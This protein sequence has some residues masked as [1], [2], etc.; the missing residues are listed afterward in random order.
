[1]AGVAV[2][3]LLAGWTLAHWPAGQLFDGARSIGESLGTVV[4]A[5]LHDPNTDIANPAVVN[6][7]RAL[8][9]YLLGLVGL[10]ALVQALRIPRE[11]LSFAAVCAGAAVGAL[12]LHWIAFRLFGLH[13]PWKR[14]ALYLAPLLTLA[15]CSIAAFEPRPILGACLAMMG[16]YFG[17][18]LRLN[19]SW[20]W[21]ICADMKDA[22]YAVA[23]LNHH[24]GVATVSTSPPFTDCLEFYRR[25]S[26]N[27]TLGEVTIDAPFVP[28][29][30][31]RVFFESQNRDLM[32]RENLRVVYRGRVDSDVVVAIRA[33]QASELV[34]DSDP[35]IQFEG[36]WAH[37]RE[38]AETSGGTV[39][40][41]NVVGDS[42]CFR[43]TGAGIRYYYTGAPNRGM[44]EVRIDGRG[45]GVVDLYSPK[46]A[47]HRERR[48]E[49]LGPG[50]HTFELRVLGRR[51]PASS[52]VYVDLDALEPI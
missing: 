41:S 39:S 3:L 6:I 5:T 46:I 13:L 33:P 26:G 23:W 21:W 15:V 11:K 38:F 28:A 8:G 7:A 51:N 12:L 40:Y 30:G 45:A 19:Y 31:A 44:A 52:G 50:E 16:L 36:S 18:C 42:V 9:P 48:F 47:W 2:V 32:V 14:T 1:M 49:N 20:E 22:Y 4:A 27:E 29:T 34:D 25:A 35:K 17:L 37:D 24:Q 43:F 10:A